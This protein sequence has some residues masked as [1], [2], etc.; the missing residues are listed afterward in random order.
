MFYRVI[1]GLLL[2]LSVCSG[3]ALC[4]RLPDPSTPLA[5]ATTSPDPYGLPKPNLVNIS[6]SEILDTPDPSVARSLAERILTGLDGISGTVQKNMSAISKLNAKITALA[7]NRA[8][9]ER[10]RARILDELKKGFYCSTCNRAKSEF[11]SEA[12]FWQHISE[13]SKEGRRA[14][15]ASNEQIQTKMNEF[16]RKIQAIQDEQILCQTAVREKNSENQI[17]YD[18]IQQGLN[19][20]QVATSF[21]KDAIY[22][23]DEA[24]KKKLRDDAA[25]AQNEL[26]RLER[27][28]SVLRKMG[29]EDEAR[30]LQDEKQTWNEMLRHVTDESNNRINYYWQNIRDAEAKQQ[31][32]FSS[33]QQYIGRTNDFVYSQRSALNFIPTLNVSV[34]SVAAYTSS[35]QLGLRFNFGSMAIGGLEVTQENSNQEVQAFM[36]LFGKLRFGAGWRTTYGMS[37]VQSGPTIYAG[38]SSKP[39]GNKL[40]VDKAILEEKPRSRLPVP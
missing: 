13:G 7:G 17:G 33:I 9:L 28:I 15:P 38:P 35:E 3:V 5:P 21:E 4:Q 24:Y 39:R 20:W 6:N 12:E 31:A 25:N 18:Q 10:D 32:E 22:A 14:V 19:L 26:S 27:E 30:M 29:K 1:G 8:K 40:K 23:Q 36:E 37:G 16:G 11:G 34:G 2:S